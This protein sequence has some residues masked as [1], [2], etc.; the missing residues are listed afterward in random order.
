M[1]MINLLNLFFLNNKIF[2]IVLPVTTDLK[3][4]NEAIGAVITKG[5]LPLAGASGVAM[6]VYAGWLIMTSQ[7]DSGKAQKGKTLLMDIF[8][9][10]LVIA[11]AYVF[12]HFIFVTILKGRFM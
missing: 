11:G 3:S 6:A 10:A 8:V 4:L 1:I 12:I 7:G 5:L 2:T 9:G